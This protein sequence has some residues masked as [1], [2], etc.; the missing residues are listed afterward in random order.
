MSTEFS[1]L[2]DHGPHPFFS[3]L[4]LNSYHNYSHTSPHRPFRL[5]RRLR[6]L[7]TPDSGVKTNQRSPDKYYNRNWC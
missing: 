3:N 1:L 7:N 5:R 6:T 2:L 4:H